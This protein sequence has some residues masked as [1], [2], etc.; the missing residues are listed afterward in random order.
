MGSNKDNRV[1]YGLIIGLLLSMST[2]DAYANSTSKSPSTSKT[3]HTE[4][5]VNMDQKDDNPYK[6]PIYL[7]LLFGYGNTN[8][9]ELV[10]QDDLSDASTPTS[11]KGSGVALGLVGGYEINKYFAV[12]TNVIRFPSSKVKFIRGSIYPISSM[13]SKTYAIS[14]AGK[15]MVP[16]GHTGVRA[17]AEAGPAYIHRADT[18]ADIGRFTPMF[19]VGANYD[20]TQHIMGEFNFQYYAGYGKSVDN[21]AYYYIPFLYTLN[22]RL[23]YRFNL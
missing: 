7:G 8:W 9:S 16:V 6:Y 4:K 3:T 11:A 23:A 18:L 5:A 21:P 12:E 1:K 22:F 10:S 20:F 19:G 13:N 14:V 17:Y 15:F 2:L